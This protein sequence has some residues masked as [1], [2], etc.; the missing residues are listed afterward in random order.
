MP[1]PNRQSLGQ[2]AELAAA[3]FLVDGG[4]TII[5]RNWRC[6]WGEIDLIAREGDEIVFVEVRSRR[7]AT[8]PAESITSRKQERLRR[9]A[10]SY[11]EKKAYP[12]E[13]LWR[14]DVVLVQLNGRGEVVQI[15]H[16]RSA[17]G[18]G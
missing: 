8:D 15:S 13:T 18:G 10:Y 6:R 17:I 3:I 16:L 2:Q 11:C 1:S 4:L 14:I 9:T 12:D 7:G 5:E